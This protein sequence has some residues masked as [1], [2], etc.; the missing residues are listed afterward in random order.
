MQLRT[1]PLGELEHLLGCV[2]TARV[3]NLLD[4]QLISNY[5]NHNQKRL[6]FAI[7]LMRAYLGLAACLN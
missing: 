1:I 5:D 6:V 7:V 3:C 4:L 2:D